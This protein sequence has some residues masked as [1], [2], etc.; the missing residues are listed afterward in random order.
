M[1]DHDSELERLHRR[2]MEQKVAISRLHTVE[3]V[4]VVLLALVLR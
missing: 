4:L 3:V 2:I 1:T